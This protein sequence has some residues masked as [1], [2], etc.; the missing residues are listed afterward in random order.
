MATGG[1]TIRST[2]L[3]NWPRR[4]DNG[5]AHHRLPG[6][7]AILCRVFATKVLFES[8]SFIL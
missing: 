5:P 8:L 4:L 1:S 6:Y 7:S 3:L 2:H